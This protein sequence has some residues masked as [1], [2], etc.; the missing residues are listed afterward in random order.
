MKRQGNLF[1]SIASFQNLLLAAER[2]Y[3][4]KRRRRIPADFHYHLERNL[5]QLENDKK[6]FRHDTKR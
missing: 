4:G 5:F 1:E 6:G 2:A 3:R